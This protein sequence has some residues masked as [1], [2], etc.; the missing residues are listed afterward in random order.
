MKRMICI[1]LAACLL[2]GS[3]MAQNEAPDYP[4][5]LKLI[6]AL[7][8]TWMIPDATGSVGYAVT[9][10]DGNGR[11][12]VIASTMGGTGL[13]TASV[14]YEVN[15]ARDGLTV[16]ERTV[17][18]GD[19][20]ADLMVDGAPVYYDPEE[21][22]YFFIFD[23]LLR[24]GP[25]SY[26]ENRRALS[27]QEGQLIEIALAYRATVYEDAEHFTVTCHDA[28]GNEI[29]EEEYATAEQ[30]RFGH[31]A[32]R[33]ASFGWMVNDDARVDPQDA[34]AVLSLLKTSWNR[35]MVF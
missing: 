28:E 24:D 11:L 3:A 34:D 17:G 14:I 2:L 12:E 4:A 22:L 23:D 26:F 25:A 15:E 20:E 32:L 1:L 10:L 31:L 19:S 33:Y 27:L 16:C 9:D 8:E 5:Q 13:Y 6:A 7:A 30:R 18:E 21:D 29:T 35:F